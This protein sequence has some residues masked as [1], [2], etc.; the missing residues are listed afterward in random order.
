MGEFV[1]PRTVLAE[2]RKRNARK[3]NSRPESSTSVDS[4][5]P[6]CRLI[7]RKAA[8]ITPKNID[9]LW[10]GRLAKGK[11]TAIAGEPGDGK[12]Q[13]SVYLAATISRGGHWP[14]DEGSAPLGTVIIFNSEDGAEDTIVPRLI[15]A[16][17]DMERVHIVSAVMQ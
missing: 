9:F 13:L 11:H 17:A 7:S 10:G 6:G 12:S 3:S 1:D 14:C 15:A 4:P 8:D 5:A 2:V 16:G